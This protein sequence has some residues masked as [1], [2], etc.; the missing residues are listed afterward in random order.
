MK[1][2]CKTNLYSQ[3]EEGKIYEVDLMYFGLI[4]LKGFPYNF[5]REEFFDIVEY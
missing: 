3:L 5:F 1:V 2:I 4:F